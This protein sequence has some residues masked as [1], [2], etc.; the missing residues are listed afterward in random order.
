MVHLNNSHLRY[1]YSIT[2]NSSIVKQQG[3]YITTLDY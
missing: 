3:C 1:L 2:C